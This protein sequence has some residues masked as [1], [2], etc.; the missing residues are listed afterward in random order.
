MMKQ[1]Y[2]FTLLEVIVVIAIMAI[3][4]SVSVAGYSSY[5]KRVNDMNM[6]I[7]LEKLAEQIMLANVGG[8]EIA[9]IEIWEYDEEVIV[10]KI[11][12][13]VFADSFP[14]HVRDAYPNAIDILANNKDNI[15][16]YTF[17]L[18]VPTYWEHDHHAADGYLVFVWSENTWRSL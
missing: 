12:S 11:Y 10:V 3:L 2:G 6:Q 7:Y 1:R 18:P 14:I 5:M 13:S 17:I 4:A 8:D 9:K 15:C 16:Y